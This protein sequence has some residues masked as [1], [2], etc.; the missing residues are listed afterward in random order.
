MQT[1]SKRCL[2]MIGGDDREIILVHSLVDKGYSLKIFGLPASMIPS[3]VIICDACREAIKEADAVILP[4]PGISNKGILYAKYLEQ[5]VKILRTDF[6]CLSPYVPVFV[7]AASPY[8]KDLAQTI[9]FPLVEVADLDEIAIPNSVPSAEG[10]IQIAMEKMLI[11]IHRSRC[12]VIGYGRVAE[13]LCAMLKGIGAEVTVVARN[14]SQLAKCRVLGYGTNFLAELPL[15]VK[16][17]DVIFNTVPSLIFDEQVL[18]HVRKDT[19][20][21]DLASSPGGTD[22]EAARRLGISAMLALGLPG[23]V[24]PLTA[25]KILAEAYPALIESH[26]SRVR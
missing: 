17:A 3:G 10:A 25:G 23:K 12:F 19:W 4:M 16:Q 20:I 13:T 8:L 22:F 24:A 5:E 26:I 21:I 18:C 1:N 7:G 9:G 11:T 6:D 2:A 15:C 14:H